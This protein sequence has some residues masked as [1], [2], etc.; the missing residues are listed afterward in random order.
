MTYEIVCYGNDVLRSEAKPVTE[1]NASIAD[2]AKNMLETMYAA[3]GLGLAAEQVGHNEAI[4]VVDVTPDRKSRGPDEEDPDADIAMPLVMI[5]PEIV[6]E[7]GE[8]RSQEGCLSFPDIY[9]MISRPAAAECAYTDLR[10]DRVT[11]KVH[12]LLAR[13]VLH[14]VD[15]LKGVLLVDRMTAVQRVAVAGKL[16]RMKRSAGHR[17]F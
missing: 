5:N 7:S 15:H 17:T 14:E 13:A 2:L 1:V 11:I 16:R 6:S 3:S 8:Q 4:C 12:G 9:A 10:G